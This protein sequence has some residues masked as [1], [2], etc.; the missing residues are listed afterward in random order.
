MI[1]R[2]TKTTEL[3]TFG[4]IVIDAAR[5]LVYMGNQ[6]GRVHVWDLH[7]RRLRLSSP[8][9]PGY[10]STI[11]VVGQTGWI[12]YAAFGDGVR[13]WN[14]ETGENRL[15]GAARPTSNLLFDTASHLTVFGT[16]AGRVEFLDFIYGEIRRAL[17]PPVIAPP[18]F[19]TLPRPHPTLP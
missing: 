2:L 16:D 11:T 3:L 17:T 19:T 5:S 1:T 12:A 6:D 7:T 4:P 14:P 9:Q 13:I 18:L 10:V 15:V 8:P